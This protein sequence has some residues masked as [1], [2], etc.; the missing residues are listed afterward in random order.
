MQWQGNPRNLPIRDGSISLNWSALG[1]WD[2]RSKIGLVWK[3]QLEPRMDLGNGHTVTL[4]VSF[5]SSRRVI[6]HDGVR[7]EYSVREDRARSYAWRRDGHDFAIQELP[8]GPRDISRFRFVVDS[9]CSFTAPGG[10]RAFV[11]VALSGTRSPTHAQ[12]VSADAANVLP[13]AEARVVD[14]DPGAATLTAERAGVYL[15]PAER[16][17]ALAHV[18]G[19]DADLARALAASARES[20]NARQFEADTALARQLSSDGDVASPRRPRAPDAPPLAPLSPRSPTAPPL[21]VASP[22]P[23]PSATWY[24]QEEPHRLTAHNPA[25]VKPPHWVAYPDD[26]QAVLEAAFLAGHPT[27]AGA[28][29]IVDLVARQQTNLRTGAKRAVLRDDAA[30]FEHADDRDAAAAFAPPSPPAVVAPPSPALPQRRPPAPSSPP[31][32]PPPS[33]QWE[34]APPSPPAVVAPRRPPAPPAPAGPPPPRQ[35]DDARPWVASDEALA[36]IAEAASIVELSTSGQ[37]LDPRALALVP[38]AHQIIELRTLI[39]AKGMET[40]SAGREPVPR[41]AATWAKLRT[42][43]AEIDRAARDAALV[44]APPSSPRRAPAPPAVSRAQELQRR[45]DLQ[46]SQAPPRPPAEDPL[47]LHARITA[48]SFEEARHWAQEGATATAAGDDEELTRALAASRA[49][50][51]AEERHRE[52]LARAL[53]ASRDVAAAEERRR[54]QC[55]TA[56]DEVEYARH[57]HIG[58]TPVPPGHVRVRV[59]PGMGPGS[60]AAFT[61]PDGR[62]LRATIPAGAT[63]DSLFDVRLPPRRT[64]SEEASPAAPPSP[65]AEEASPGRRG[66]VIRIFEEARR[67]HVAEE[68]TAKDAVPP[69]SRVAG[70]MMAESDSDSDGDGD[71]AKETARGARPAPPPMLGGVPDGPEQLVRNIEA[72]IR[73]LN[74]RARADFRRELAAARGNISALTELNRRVAQAVDEEN[75]ADR[76]PEPAPIDREAFEALL[77]GLTDDSD[78][79]DY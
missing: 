39:G 33:R 45:R 10:Q 51:A 38:W 57:V 49:R 22:S 5:R 6:I 77:A 17:A 28:N 69:R 55:A 14:A 16:Q 24:W 60:E 7:V 78:E 66:D 46:R 34:E 19:V 64:I 75:A 29:N 56:D 21:P 8:D 53:E 74:S 61:A 15:T 30:F 71:E 65:P 70:R 1:K 9:A 79:D 27:C 36:D 42:Q 13:V 41:F 72:H 67:R 31:T 18:A 43:R 76:E 54:V 23:R 25:L 59:P 12:P 62:V 52:D 26:V 20:A 32:G 11:D 35:W 44:E 48:L 3:F 40:L 68:A 4:T 63:E 58:E 37:S 2:P 47:R 50:A 73:L